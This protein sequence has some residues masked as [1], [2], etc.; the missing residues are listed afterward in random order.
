MCGRGKREGSRGVRER[1]E[2]EGDIE[3]GRGKRDR[4]ER[5]RELRTFSL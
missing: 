1:E 4:R 3:G 2:I 5:K